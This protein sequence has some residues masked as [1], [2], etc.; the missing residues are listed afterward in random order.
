MVHSRSLSQVGL[1]FVY[2]PMINRD[3][4]ITGMKFESNYRPSY[5]RSGFG[6]RLSRSLDYG[7]YYM[8]CG[9]TVKFPVSVF[10][11]NFQKPLFLT[12]CTLNPV[13]Q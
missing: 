11:L 5:S 9:C 10:T 3:R 6:S 13:S 12:I 2:L 7:E 4:P 1:D 8:I